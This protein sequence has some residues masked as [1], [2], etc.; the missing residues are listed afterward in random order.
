VL[1]A[2]AED[3]SDRRLNVG[4]IWINSI[5]KP[6]RVMS[7]VAGHTNKLN[8]YRFAMPEPARFETGI[9]ST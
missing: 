9:R 7:C 6:N 4:L 8:G 5:M 3:K 1:T 2:I